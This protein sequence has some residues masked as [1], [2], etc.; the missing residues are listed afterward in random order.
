MEACLY[1]GCWNT[2]GHHLFA[3]NGRPISRIELERIAERFDRGTKHIDGALAPRK[4][5]FGE[6]VSISMA[7]SRKEYGSFELYCNECPQGQF[8]LHHLDNGYTAIQWWDR[9]QGDRRGACNSTILLEGIHTSIEMI[10]A[11]KMH[12]P[13][14]IDNLTRNGVNLVEVQQGCPEGKSE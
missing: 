11:A 8:L 7:T 6:I 1:F 2:A 12:F 13:H 10:D 5:R 3:P 9:S 4:S 14:V